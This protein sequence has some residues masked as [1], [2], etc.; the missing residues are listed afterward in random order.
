M[1]GENKIEK[2]KVIAIHNRNNDGS[3]YLVQYNDS[4][5]RAAC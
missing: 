1:K 3:I 4:N 2:E 5:G